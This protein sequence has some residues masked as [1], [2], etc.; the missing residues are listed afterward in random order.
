MKEPR[1]R[2]DEGGRIDR[3]T[4][5]SFRFNGQSFI[6]YAGD[7]LASALL[8]YGA[9][10]VGRGFKYHRPRGIFAAGAEEPNALIQLETGG[11]TQPNLRATQVELYENLTATSVN[12]WPS[13]DFDVM[14]VNDWLSPIFPSGFYYKTFMGSGI[15]AGRWWKLFE[16]SIRRAAGF[17][18]APRSPDPDRYERMNAHCDVL[19]VGAGPAG[20]AAALVAAQ[21]GCRVILM[22]EQSEIG[23]D[24]LAGDR[25]IN[26][27]PA[28]DWVAAAAKTL[29][30]APEVRVLTRTIVAGL[31]DDNF[32]TAL[33]TVG[34]RFGPNAPGHL[35]RHRLWRIRATQVVL[36]TG[37]HE[38]PYAFPNND[39]PGVMLGQALRHYAGRYGV[40][41][42]QHV[43]LGTNNDSA[44]RTAR[45][46]ADAGVQVTLADAR[47]TPP[48][49]LVDEASKAGV[50]VEPGFAISAVAG[51][52]RVRAGEI[53]RIL[54]DGE[55]S[56][57]PRHVDA[58][59][60][61]VSGGW[62]PAL[63]L[64]S[65]RGAKPEWQAEG[66]CFVP[67]DLRSLGVHV[68]GAVTGA[69]DLSACLDQGHAAG[70]AAAKAAGQT[71]RT[72][73][74]KIQTDDFADPA[75]IQP[76]WSVASRQP[77]GKK[78]KA[79]VDFQNDVTT[80]D[81][82]L[83]ARE[84]YRSVEHLKRYT[85]LGMGTDQGKTSNVIGLALM[86][87]ATDR[88]PDAVGTT[89]FRPP[90]T[91]IPLGALAGRDR[92]PLFDPVRETPMFDWHVANGAV[93]EDVGQWRRPYAYLRTG[94]T[95][96]DAINR[97]VLAV[98]NK[99]GVLDASTL[100]KIDLKGPDVRKLLNLIYTNDWETLKVGRARYGLMCHEDGMIFD[101][102]VTAR[103]GEDHYMLTTTSGNAT[104]VLAWMEEWL[105][106]EWP[107][108]KVFTTSVTEAYATATVAGPAG[109]TLLASLDSDIDW[110]NDAFPHMSA[111]TG[112]IMGV[113]AHVFRVSFS[114]EASWEINV[115]AH[116]GAALWEALIAGGATPYGT[117]AMHVLRAE[118]GFIIVGQE[119][120]GTVTPF[121]V[122]M[123]WAVSKR[124]DFIGKRSF[125]R[126]DTA[127]KDRKQLVGLLPA[128]KSAVLPEGGQIVADP[129]QETPKTM[130]GHITSSYW[131]PTLNSGFAL[132]LLK[133]GR[134]RRGDT[135]YILNLEGG[136]DEARIVDP[137]FY[138]KDGGRM[139]G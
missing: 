26:D 108:L 61:G 103:L 25:T 55:T 97:E 23:G 78:G 10:P 2:L 120:D 38:R 49:I 52:R 91:P 6:G 56:G 89:N 88:A 84:N 96:Q 15:A 69:G 5:L 95:L 77:G 107:E 81:V 114:G 85:T 94:E 16:P 106:T 13:V 36:A 136:A 7:T 110:S 98:R 113:P 76:L 64:A 115:P 31:Y 21:Q 65:H 71:K 129:D 73:K 11:K 109:R 59:L 125:S 70:K 22:D 101:D 60:V 139:R 47:E 122:G 138:D 131:S 19:V 111:V 32:A 137:D 74:R 17:G 83:A 53:S 133:N 128:E 92:G 93:F 100:G 42:G 57:A 134:K 63:H 30:N 117:E 43:L 50:T 48:A 27:A 58:D 9:F 33:E 119:T 72:R 68:A 3:D 66:A 102:G 90:Y 105:Q 44:Y 34:D 86:G 24:L 87:V 79:F 124:K 8:A 116:R 51:G 62:N 40:V 130:L 80:K 18:T 28:M 99:V 67:A 45:L 126:S 1:F 104:A 46:L 112:T 54:P 123:G 135:V 39:A 75:P 121:D 14:R 35:P 41:P 127:R 29:A 20:V 82:A 12:A 132:G 4:P 37:A 118:K